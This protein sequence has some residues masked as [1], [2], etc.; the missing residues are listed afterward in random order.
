[1]HEA[2][3]AVFA[4]FCR[5]R[6]KE[7]WINS[8]VIHGVGGQVSVESLDLHTG[9]ARMIA[10]ALMYSGRAAEL[11]SWDAF[12]N[13]AFRQTTWSVCPQRLIM[14]SILM[15]TLVVEMDYKV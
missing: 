3:H 6:I 1:V 5:I 10:A 13:T 2:G 7:V 9:L 8:S 14:S 15:P 11:C 12:P 4:D